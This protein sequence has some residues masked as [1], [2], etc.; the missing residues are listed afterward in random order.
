MDLGTVGNIAYWLGALILAIEQILK[1]APE[2]RAR[3]PRFI[4]SERWNYAPLALLIVAGSI[5]VA[6]AYLV[7]T[8]TAQSRNRISV[9]KVDYG[10]STLAKDD[11]HG[12]MATFAANER[13]ESAPDNL[14]DYAI[15]KS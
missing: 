10:R 1:G 14:L 8:L 4:A 5:W 2:T 15:S 13:L 11:R 12:E 7:P 3:L 6:R 9:P